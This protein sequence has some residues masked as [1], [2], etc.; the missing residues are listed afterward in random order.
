MFAGNSFAGGRAC[1]ADRNKMLVGAAATQ[2]CFQLS[3]A[4]GGLL[5]SD[6]DGTAF[7][8]ANSPNYYLSF[9]VNSLDLWKFHVDWVN[10]ANS[11]FAGPTNFAVASFSEACAGGACIPHFGK[12]NALFGLVAHR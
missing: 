2:Q 5:P 1:V 9:G 11:T 10:T 3:N 4:Y 12:S 6:L 7:P 8:P